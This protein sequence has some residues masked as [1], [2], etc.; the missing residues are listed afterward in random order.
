MRIQLSNWLPNPD[1][2]GVDEVC[3]PAAVSWLSSASPAC[4]GM[5]T[6]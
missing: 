4:G 1:D 5:T 3:T 6:V 2:G